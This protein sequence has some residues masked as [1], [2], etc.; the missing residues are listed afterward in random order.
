MAVTL[1]RATK[2]A[3]FLFNFAYVIVHLLSTKA[4]AYICHLGNDMI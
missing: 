3:F 1:Y 2:F 4:Y